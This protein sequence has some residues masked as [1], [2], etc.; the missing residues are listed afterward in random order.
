MSDERREHDGGNEEYGHAQQ[1]QIDDVTHVVDDDCALSTQGIH[2]PGQLAAHFRNPFTALGGRPRERGQPLR[3]DAAQQFA[4]FRGKRA[5]H[6]ADR[7]VQLDGNGLHHQG[8]LPTQFIEDD[9]SLVQ[10]E[11]RNAFGG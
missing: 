8:S 1:D 7:L 5:D 6:R 11:R 4:S 2:R 3:L 10:D 9:P